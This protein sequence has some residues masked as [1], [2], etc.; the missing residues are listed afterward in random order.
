MKNAGIKYTDRARLILAEAAKDKNK[1]SGI[2]EILVAIMTVHCGLAQYILTESGI[3]REDLLALSPSLDA[4]GTIS[5]ATIQQIAESLAGDLQHPYLG[6]EHLLLA[7]LK[8]VEGTPEEPILRQSLSIDYARAKSAVMKILIPSKGDS[9]EIQATHVTMLSLEEA[10]RINTDE[11]LHMSSERDKVK[12]RYSPVWLSLP[13]SLLSGIRDMIEKH[14]IACAEL[15]PSDDCPGRIADF[16]CRRGSETAR[17]GVGRVRSSG[18][19]LALVDSDLAYDLK[20]EIASILVAHGA[21]PY[22]AE[23]EQ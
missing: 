2:G 15:A 10:G 17:V 11:K 9:R 5:L 18:T 22:C 12:A 19:L 8:L 14:G 6:S 13:E 1:P 21:K 3:E 23:R 7:C 20:G 16:R 4:S